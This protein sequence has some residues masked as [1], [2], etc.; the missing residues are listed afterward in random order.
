MWFYILLKKQQQQQTKN[1]K[2]INKQ[3]ANLLK[4]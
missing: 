1:Q 3:K 4:K 2:Q